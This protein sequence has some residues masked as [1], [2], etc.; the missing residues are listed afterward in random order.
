MWIGTS[1]LLAGI[2]E[3]IKLGPL[4]CYHGMGLMFHV[5]T[6]LGARHSKWYLSNILRPFATHADKPLTYSRT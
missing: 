3:R 1:F 6:A 2:C 5:R 4:S